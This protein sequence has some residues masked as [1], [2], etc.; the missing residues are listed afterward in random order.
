MEF[1]TF[2]GIVDAAGK[3][4]PRLLALEHDG[5]PCPGDIAAFESAL[6]IQLPEKYK[7]FLLRFGGGYF[8]IANLYSLDSSSCFY[9]LNHNRLPLG[10]EL[11]IA[12]NG[13]GDCYALRIENG[14]CRDPIFFYDHE[15]R[16]ISDAAFP[17][18][19]TYLASVGLK[20]QDLP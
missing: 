3:E 12:D 1:D 17:D 8:G 6:Q 2:L 15:S 19:L 7:Q 5:I 4:R 14:I 18:V 16:E 9:L 11:L 13:C 20:M 10:N